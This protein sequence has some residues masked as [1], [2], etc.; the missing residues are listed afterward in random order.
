MTIETTDTIITYRPIHE[1]DIPAAHA[2]T[3]AVRWPHRIEDWEAVVRL[4]TGFAAEEHGAVVGTALWSV[5]GEHQASL[6]MVPVASSGRSMPVLCDR[7]SSV[8]YLAMVSIPSFSA[9]V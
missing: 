5:Q 8:A 7:P 2:L 9:S 6:G 3:Q 1:D 4:G